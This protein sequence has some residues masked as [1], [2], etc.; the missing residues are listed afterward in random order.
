[1]ELRHQCIIYKGAPSSQLPTFASLVRQ[2]LAEGWRCLYLNRPSM[3]AGLR[4]SLAAIGVDVAAEVAKRRLLLSSDSPAAAGGSFEIDE[5]LLLLEDALNQ[6]IADGF[7]GL[8]ASGD[9]SWEFGAENNFAK[10][11]E[12]EHQLEKLFRRNTRLCGI[13]QYHRDSI[14]ADALRHGLLSHRS[15]FINESLSRTNPHYLPSG[16]LEDCKV[17][18]DELDEVIDAFSWLGFDGGL[19]APSAFSDLSPT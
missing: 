12:Y 9:M 1:M 4:S 14:P 6:A 11:L 8:W 15:I 7:K 13:C 17:S 5:M 2:K 18:N 3:V 10:L 19:S 16:R